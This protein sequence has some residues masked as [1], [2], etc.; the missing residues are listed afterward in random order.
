MW[1]AKA[2]GWLIL[3]PGTF[4]WLLAAALLLIWAGRR[5][6]A[7]VLVAIS[8]LGLYGLAIPPVSDALL[9]PLEGH[10]ADEPLA[11]ERCDA[12]AVMSGGLTRG[13]DPGG[14][15]ALSG[16]SLKRT[17]A[18]WRLWRRLGV[19]LLLSGGNTWD[20]AWPEAA[21][22]A[23]TLRELGVPDGEI[24][25]EPRSRN[26]FENAREA[27]VEA[28][29]HGWLTLCLVTSAYHLPRTHRAFRAAGLDTV[30]VPTDFRGTP[31]GA[32]DI[33]KRLVPTAGTF[34]GSVSALREYVA[35]VWYAL[36]Y[37]V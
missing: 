15:P 34:A 25:V 6:A 32:G 22:M 18:G 24:V 19:P 35:F 10:Y 30:P 1:T 37:G 27:R 26:T 20:V 17:L 23:E 13:P 3:P 7:A 9:A 16:S 5:R 2:I 11:V 28:E 31:G 12:I 14:P 33:W 21:V 8:L 36:R 29:T 4:V